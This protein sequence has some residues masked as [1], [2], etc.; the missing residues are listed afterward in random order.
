[1][2]VSYHTALTQALSNLKYYWCSLSW[3]CPCRYCKSP[4]LTPFGSSTWCNSIISSGLKLSLHFSHR[5]SC[6]LST[7]IS[8]FILALWYDIRRAKYIS[9]PLYI[10]AP[11][12]IFMYLITFVESWRFNTYF[13]PLSLYPKF[14]PCTL[15]H[16]FLAFSAVLYLFL[17]QCHNFQK[18]HLSIYEKYRVLLVTAKYLVHPSIRVANLL[19]T[20]SIGSFLYFF[21]IIFKAA[22]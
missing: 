18:S 6:F 13:F 16:F 7:A 17:A 22:L 19:I 14:H 21:N 5:Y 9:S 4:V 20:A 12:L 1:M 3:Q 15:K 2:I 8:R 10:D 11:A